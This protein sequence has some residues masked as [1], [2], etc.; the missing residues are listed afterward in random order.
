MKISTSTCSFE[1]FSNEE[2]VNF[3]AE[4]G[5]DALDFSLG[6]KEFYDAS[7]DSDSF[8]ES[9]ITLRKMA[10]DKGLV[11]NQAHA[12]SPWPNVDQRSSVTKEAFD[13]MV[14]CIRNA[15]YLGAKIIVIH[16]CQHLFY[17][18]EGAPEKL[19]EINVEFYKELIPYCEEYGIQVATEN[20]FQAKNVDFMKSHYCVT[21]SA[22]S[23]P[24]E[25][26]RYVDAVDSPWIT[27]C[28]DLG[29]AEIL[30]H[31]SA[32]FIRT[33]GGNR[34]KAL[35]IQDVDGFYDLHTMP[36]FGG[37]I[38]WDKAMKALAEIGYEGDLTF[39]VPGYFDALPKELIPSAAKLL[40][41]TGKHLRNKFLAAK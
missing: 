32:Y 15:S 19:F 33:L 38:D 18:D 26:C 17:L 16:P 27:A 12:M 8:K 4:A 24:A 11:F 37:M 34:L 3:V 40:A 30:S 13:N 20:M 41:D 28:L 39:E 23:D 25:F 22:C 21:P 1:Q 35:H 5:F 6:K 7:T 9:F 31:D 29:H 14:R 2:M 10:E 36:Y